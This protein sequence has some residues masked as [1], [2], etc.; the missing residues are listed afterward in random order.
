LS[1]GV[2]VFHEDYFVFWVVIINRIALYIKEMLIV[3]LLYYLLLILRACLYMY[4]K[5]TI[6]NIA[7]GEPT[8]L[9]TS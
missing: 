8:N 4:S 3:K 1:G 7:N 5:C 6:T 2:C 9:T